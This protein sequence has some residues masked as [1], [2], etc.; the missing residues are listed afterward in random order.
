MILNRA[1]LAAE[2]DYLIFTDGDCIP[3]ADFVATHLKFRR[4]KHFL[5]GGYFKLPMITSET[6]TK[7]DI[8]AQRCFDVHWLQQNGLKAIKK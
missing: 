6:I 2:T 8:I 1:I 4:P 7:E 5:S 3:R